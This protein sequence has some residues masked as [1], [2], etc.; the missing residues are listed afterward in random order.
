M[1]RLRL[2]LPLPALRLPPAA[3]PAPG[4]RLRASPLARRLATEAGLALAGIQGTGPE[5][6]IIAEDIR[7][8]AAAAA[9]KPAAAAG[10]AAPK[11]S[12]SLSA[13]ALAEA[14]ERPFELQPLSNVRRTIAARLSESKR[15]VPHY[16]LA[17]N[18]RIDSLLA[19]RG[20]LNASAPEGAEG[21]A[22]W[23]LSLNDL[24]LRATALALRDQP[25]SN[26]SFDESGLVFWQT[27]DLAFAV[28]TEDGLFTPVL[29]EADQLLLP[30]LSSAVRSLAAKARAGRLKPQEYLGGSFAV[31]NLGMFGV[32]DFAAVINPPQAGILAVG[33]AEQRVF[34]LEGG[35]K[36]ERLG[37]APDPLHGPPGR[38]RS[39]G[40]RASGLH[41]RLLGSSVAPRPARACEGRGER[42]A[43]RSGRGRGQG[44]EGAG[45]EKR[46]R[47]VM[48]G[49]VLGS[50]SAP[51]GALR[52][53]EKAHR[54][55]QG[56]RRGKPPWLRVKA[57]GG[58]VFRETL[59][60]VRAHGL[61]TVCEE[62]G[63]PNI[64][65]CWEQRHAT[66][67]ILGAV[68]TRACSFCNVATGAPEAADP[69]E[70]GRVAKA[71][72]DLGL[73][74]VVITSVD[75]DDLPD[76]GASH[77]AQTVRALRHARP[78]DDDRD[79][80]AR[81]PAQ[82]RGLGDGSLRPRPMS[83]TT[84]SRP[85]RASIPRCARGRATTTA[86]ACSTGPSRPGLSSSPSRG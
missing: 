64:G 71:V 34:P 80:D 69:F 73:R 29:R 81:L 24:V 61:A 62:A 41:R 75:R 42:G 27:V 16:Y 40:G 59:A 54:P 39:G 22:A 43:G 2:R 37:P 78:G 20:T 68:C 32:S 35:G 5:G 58:A 74:H 86:C 11:S 30:E 7:R 48:S 31:S 17:R 33:A 49:I 76:G 44:R 70:P 50:P 23:K 8:A 9:A 72:R 79:L 51:K 55:S 65:E 52:H 77:F 4:A 85:Y 53:P 19:L 56:V 1:R 45:G 6:R 84:T 38:G 57:P 25:R 10:T 26:C 28:A 46:R 66:M 47:G 67:M 83:S 3:A 63:C 14:L 12:G 13:R 21:K 18:C 82:E 15:E 60:T 36:R